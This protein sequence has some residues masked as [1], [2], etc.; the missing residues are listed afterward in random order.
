VGGTQ[1]TNQNN[2]VG[3]LGSATLNVNFTDR[4]L[5][6]NAAVSI[7]ASGSAAGGSWQLAA[8]GVPIA[9]NS[10]YA[11][12]LDR[13]TIT[14]GT[15]F[16]SRSTNDLS[17]AFQGSFAGTGLAIAVLGYGISDSTASSLA[18]WHFV[19][20]VAA[21]ASVRQNPAAEYREGRISDANGAL[22]E[23]VR[24]FAT[25]NRP[26]EVTLDPQNRVTAFSAPSATL[27]AHSTYSLG[28]AQ[29]VESGFDAETGMVWG[30]WGGGTATV[31][32]GAST[33][34][35]FLNDRSLH[36]IFAGTQS[37]PVALPLTGTAVYDVI[38]STHP[39]DFNGHVGTLNTATLNANFTNRTVDAA[40]NIAI[41]GQTWNGAAQGM[42]IYR[43]QYFSAYSGT[44]IAGVPNPAP[45]V[46]TCQP[47]C[48]QGA[49][50]SFDG[51][52][53]GRSGGR[54]GLMYNLGGNQGAVA[55]GRRGG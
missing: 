13:L 25:T 33:E 23:F 35:L 14:N 44:P 52:F 27:G 32:R 47:S 17:G 38:G 11:S 7:P 29:I 49:G 37:G 30:R 34:Q 45:L 41:A 19:S 2:V 24:S 28:T 5:G 15:G 21:F 53:S 40:V 18:N 39:T 48:G 54:A 43:D 8:T 50:G 9:L 51:F 31:T 3:A 12:T 22:T 36:Y 46:V 10:F 16:N 55:F 4:T 26:D 20:G 1:P 6:F 42:P